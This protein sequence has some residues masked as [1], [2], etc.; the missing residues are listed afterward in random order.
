[1][2]PERPAVPR[3]TPPPPPPSRL[4]VVRAATPRFGAVFDPWNSASTGH[5]RA[6]SSTGTGWRDSRSKKLNAQLGAGDG[7]G[8]ARLSDTWGGGAEDFDPE[9]RLLVPRW[10]RERRGRSVADMLR[11]PGLMRE[12]LD[13]RETPTAAT[14]GARTSTT[15]TTAEEALME[16]RRRE[17]EAREEERDKARR[18]RGIFDG[19]VI[20]V[21]GSTF[22]LVSDHRLKQIVTE[23]GGYV[24]LHLGRRRVTHVILGRSLAAGKIEKEV[25]RLG[26]VGVKYVGVEWCV[27]PY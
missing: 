24:S 8:G 3:G 27:T 7:S 26:G 20:Y 11:R 9:S 1:M 14:A 17:D 10:V 19:L 2:N 12:T 5:Q 6:D 16:A 23:N 15:T 18:S 21:N 25:R 13:Q 22:P 4:S